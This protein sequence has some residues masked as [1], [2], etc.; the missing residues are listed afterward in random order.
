MYITL[1]PVTDYNARRAGCHMDVGES[2]T[3]QR[4]MVVLTCGS[5][6]VREDKY[7]IVRAN[8]VR[9]H[10]RLRPCAPTGPVLGVSGAVHLV[11]T[12]NMGA[13]PGPMALHGHD[14]RRGC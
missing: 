13:P 5:L 6:S 1:K 3:E 11:V 8:L 4:A 14:G 10:L 2:S 12:A 7:R 9:E